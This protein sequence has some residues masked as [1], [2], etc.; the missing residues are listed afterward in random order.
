[1]GETDDTELQNSFIANPESYFRDV[2]DRYSGPLFRFLYRFTAN[3][4]A[5]EE[6]LQDL[7]LELL[8][9]KFKSTEGGALKAW[10]FTVAKNRG[11]NY[12]KKNSREVKI[13]LSDFSSS[14][15]LENQ[16]IEKN[17]LRRLSKAVQSLPPDLQETWNL[18]KSG[19]DYQEIATTLSIPVG[20]VKSRFSRLVEYLRK[21]FGYES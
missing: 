18:R 6:I 7:F 10:L 20:T 1:M 4:H 5:S 14:V 19:L 8:A 17:L 21:E 16:V 15:D 13:D 11:L 9:G 2:Y 12:H 3:N